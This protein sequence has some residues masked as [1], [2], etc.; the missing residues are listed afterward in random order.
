MRVDSGLREGTTIGGAYDPMLAKVV[1][2]GPDRAAA[3]RRLDQALAGFTVLGVTTNVAFLRGLLAD[4]EVAAGRL[5]TGLAERSRRQRGHQ[6]SRPPCSPPR[7]WT[8]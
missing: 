3:V 4:P 5:D 7:P 8:A 6:G 1:A 2:W